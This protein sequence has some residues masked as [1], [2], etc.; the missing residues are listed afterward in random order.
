MIDTL[1]PGADS[2]PFKALDDD[3][4]DMHLG[5]ALG[6]LS[7]VLILSWIYLIKSRKL[8]L[9]ESVVFFSLLSWL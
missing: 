7:A 4:L 1:V 8:F 9:S 5:Y 6:A 2:V 3:L